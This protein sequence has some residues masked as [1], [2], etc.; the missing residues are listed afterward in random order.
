MTVGS[1]Q[2]LPYETSDPLAY[3]W[4]DKAFDMCNGANPT[5]FGSV[6][7][8][9]GVSRAVVH[10]AC[11]R[12]SG[13]IQWDE[14]LSASGESGVL[15]AEGGGGPDPY[16]RVNVVCDCV[17]PHPRRPEGVTRGCGIGFTLEI[18]RGEEG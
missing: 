11:P 8:A 9:D 7:R 4:T 17:L 16:A 12:C 13:D 18:F 15:G 14:Q 6:R 5:L 1:H 10:G 3:E 2:E